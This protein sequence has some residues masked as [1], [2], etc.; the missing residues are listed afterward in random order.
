[1]TLADEIRA[2]LKAHGPQ[3][4][5]AIRALL[6]DRR[7]SDGNPRRTRAR[8]VHSRLHAMCHPD[9]QLDAG[10]I[11]KKLPG[12]L[13]QWLRDPTPPMGRAERLARKR[14]TQRKY[15]AHR[16]KPAPAIRSAAA[17]KVRAHMVKDYATRAQIRA[18][19]SQAITRRDL[20]QRDQP[21]NELPCSD[22]FIAANARKP[23]AYEVLAPG[24]VGPSSQF[25]ALENVA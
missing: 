18:E 24:K 6:P 21:A 23:G 7:D 13:Y 1:M 3:D 19:A 22:A 16:P 20:G 9:R 12:D 10:P 5:R 15:E 8:E 2:L 25:R 4:A 11:L 17:P 14:E